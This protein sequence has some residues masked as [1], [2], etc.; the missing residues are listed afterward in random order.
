MGKKHPQI[1]KDIT[2]EKIATE[3]KGIGRNDGKIVFVDFAI[4]GDI[5]DVYVQKNKKD[6]AMGNIT[7]LSTPS[8]LR[9]APRCRHFGVCGGCK[10][11]N[12]SYDQQLVYKHKIVE[13]SFYHL[14]K[15]Q[16]PEFLPII[17]CEEAF[18]YRNK[19]DYSATNRRWLTNEQI[20]SVEEFEKIGIGFHV[21][22]KFEAVTHIEECVLM[23]DYHNIIRNTIFDY[24]IQQNISCYNV[25]NHQGMFRNIIIRNTTDGQW[26][27]L[28]VFGEEDRVIIDKF[29]QDI[30]LSLPEVA[31]LLFAINKKYND[32]IYDL[33]IQVF[34]GNTEIIEKLDEKQFYIHIKSFFQTNPR[35]AKVLYDT[36]R[37]M[38]P[39]LKD[40]IIYDLYTGTGSI[41]IYLSD[42]CQSMI[43]IELNPDAIED[44]ERNAELNG[45][46]NC[47]F[48]DSAAEKLFDSSFVEKYGHPDIVITDP[49]R[50]GMH[51]DVIKTLLSTSP[52][53]IIYV[54]CNPS[55][56]ARDIAMLE[57]KYIIN[58]IQPIDMFPHTY[59]VENVV[60]LSLRDIK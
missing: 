26:I 53:H 3:G 47:T 56:Q 1:F 14:L 16:S 32:S 24:L 10:W 57:E 39:I 33:D 21:P 12:I 43:G 31:N 2:I 11:Q 40:S 35:Q 23:D 45:I 37:A 29:M 8:P 60:L 59:H 15:N 36:V 42:L 17:G 9:I 55:T 4:P 19:M 38:T 58:K 44:A 46:A 13:E 22:G 25:H 34:K 20:E 49:P 6:Y 18:Y 52:K 50:S 28:I 5:V 51:P 54:S 7:K 27:V 30:A 41:A 48:F